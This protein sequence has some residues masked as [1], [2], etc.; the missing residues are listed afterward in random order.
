MVGR[1][2]VEKAPEES[3]VGGKVTVKVPWAKAAM[4][5]RDVLPE[6]L[7]LVPV[8]RGPTW[9]GGNADGGPGSP[10]LALSMEGTQVQVMWERGGEMT[11]HT[12][13]YGA[14]RFDVVP[15]DISRD[16]FDER[17]RVKAASAAAPDASV[18]SPDEVYA[19]GQ[20]AAAAGIKIKMQ[21]PSPA[22]SKSGEADAPQ[23]CHVTV[24]RYV[25][26]PEARE[27]ASGDAAGAS[28]RLQYVPRA[29]LRYIS[30]LSLDALLSAPL[31]RGMSLD[32]NPNAVRELARALSRAVKH[33]SSD[34]TVSVEVAAL[35]QV[36]LQE[37][38]DRLLL[39]AG[40]GPAVPRTS[41]QG[42][43]G[44]FAPE[45]RVAG[46]KAVVSTA[47]VGE[48]RSSEPPQAPGQS[49]AT[50]GQDAAASTVSQAPY[51]GIK[52]VNVSN[53]FEI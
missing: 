39:A 38:L 16:V 48:E 11:T 12:Y 1:N 19:F 27:I 30:A 23:E 9:Q 40:E 28:K 41:L 51:A 2:P 42:A 43:D 31:G 3:A 49:A 17:Q 5:A 22:S 10:G 8:V 50:A 26:G 4:P 37:R 18:V 21:R 35:N 52:S 33:A 45:T 6:A 7:Q 15:T 44:K 13:D 53:V 36:R 32:A 47:A 25:T 24:E 20:S 14:D 29:L 46:G 34:T